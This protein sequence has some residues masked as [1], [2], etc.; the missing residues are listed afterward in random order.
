M[1]EVVQVATSDLAGLNALVRQANGVWSSGASVQFAYSDGSKTEQYLAKV[2]SEANDVSCHSDELQ[3]AIHDWPSEYHLSYQRSQLFACLEFGKSKTALELGCGCGAI[4]RVLG[5]A[6]LMVD[7]IEGSKIRADLAAS[8]CRDLENVNIFNANYNALS[9]PANH[10]DFVFFVGVL[11]YAQRF[12]E[13]A[14][15]SRAAVLQIL[16]DI[17]AALKPGGVVVIAIENRLG[18][19]Y[20]LGAGEDHLYKPNVGLYGYPGNPSDQ[21]Y[22][23]SEWLQ[24]LNESGLAST[25][26]LYPFPDYK[27]PALVLTQRFLDQNKH[28]ATALMGISSQDHTGCVSHFE[29]EYLY[30]KS[31]QTEGHLGEYANSFLILASSSEQAVSSVSHCDFS[32]ISSKTRASQYRAVTS[33]IGSR[34]KVRKQLVLKTSVDAIQIPGALE[35]IELGAFD[36]VDGIRLDEQ[37]LGLLQHDHTG[38][39]FEQAVHQYYTFV[40][41]RLAQAD[42]LDY[43]DLLP[44]NIIV[45]D[46]G[47]W[48]VIDQEWRSQDDLE[49]RFLLFRSLVVFATENMAKIKQYCLDRRIENVKDFTLHLLSNTGKSRSYDIQRFAEMENTFQTQVTAQ[50]F[51]IPLATSLSRSFSSGQSIIKVLVNNTRDNERLFEDIQNSE[52]TESW[53]IFEFEIPGLNQQNSVVRIY[54]GVSEDWFSIRNIA[55]DSAANDA[56]HSQSLVLKNESD[57]FDKLFLFDIY[58]QDRN[59]EYPFYSKTGHGHLVMDVPAE[60]SACEKLKLCFELKWPLRAGQSEQGLDLQ[61]HI[62]WFNQR[63][64]DY[65]TQSAFLR[66]TL[67]R[68]LEAAKNKAEKFKQNADRLDAELKLVKSSK[69]WRYAERFRNVFYRRILGH[70]PGLQK[71]FLV[72]SRRQAATS[73]N[74]TI[75]QKAAQNSTANPAPTKSHSVNSEL[76]PHIAVLQTD[77]VRPLTDMDVYQQR[78]KQYELDEARRIQIMDE[79]NAFAVKPRISIVMPVYNVKGKWLERAVATVK[80]QCYQ[81]WELCIV[82]DCSTLKSTKLALSNI[83]H[84]QIK[85]RALQ[86]NKNISA[87]TNEAL[88]MVDGEY[89]AFMDHDDELAIDALFEVVKS[90][91]IDNPDFI[92]T[93]EDFISA[94]GFRAQPHY[95]PDFSP[96]LLLSHNYITHFVVITKSLLDRTGG[97]RSC[98]DGAQDYDF[99]LRATENAKKITHIPKV[100]YHWRMLEQSTSQNADAKPEAISR[101]RN[102]VAEALIRRGI[103][104]TVHNANMPHFSRVKRNIVEAPLVSII[105]AF[106]NDGNLLVQRIHECL[107]HTNYKNFEILLIS[108]QPSL[109]GTEAVLKDLEYLD[110]RISVVRTLS[111]FTQASALNRG[112]DLARGKHLAFVDINVEIISWDWMDSLLE[113]SQRNEV[114]VVGGKTFYRKGHIHQAGYVLYRD[115]QAVL[116]HNKLKSRWPGYFNR[117]NLIQNVSAVPC[118]FMMC[119]KQV[120]EQLRGFD[121]QEPFASTFDIDFCLRALTE[122]YI[123]VMTPYAQAYWCDSDAAEVQSDCDLQDTSIGVRHKEWLSSGDPFYSP[124]LSQ[125]GVAY[126]LRD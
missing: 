4:T 96:D 125:S 32:Y 102:V 112:A 22:S 17:N 66:D 97:L 84:P 101:S 46:D 113:H 80:S 85:V 83:Q 110:E 62:Q 8:R 99:V 5:E 44:K 11:E 14:N 59:I 95:K 79:I 57:I 1:S 64:K 39:Q 100:L 103:E 118:I 82:D 61:A 105:L 76:P 52:K 37:W 18:L 24:I 50:D 43:V 87:A 90:I 107:D 126:E 15:S 77:S 6:G 69:V 120:F 111:A 7:A 10:Y 38:R 63:Q 60:F 36:Y 23:K 68:Q 121:D 49:P 123:N 86:K 91:N 67:G 124:N 20:L 104:A 53:K 65:L 48:H 47:E 109:S 40:C 78:I 81:N 16:S 34:G 21:T 94:D 117:A 30:W 72:L 51:A 9:L 93:D 114:G 115:G 45:T 54:P 26:F 12:R 2:L 70:L 29:N 25:E 3:N 58:K 75:S 13:D 56:V 19:K 122:K 31:L 71:K 33:Q 42:S 35:H 108:K 73:L 41:D 74:T 89:I 55:L 106:E 88:A 119:S 28:A 98:F 116:A 27:I 92:Y